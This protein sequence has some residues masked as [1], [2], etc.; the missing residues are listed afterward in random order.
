M[1]VSNLHPT[2]LPLGEGVNIMDV[3]WAQREFEGANLRDKRFHRSLPEIAN[4]LFCASECS[5]TQAVGQDGRQ[6]AHRLMSNPL[7]NINSI[8][9]GHYKQ[10]A[11]RASAYPLILALQDTVCIGYDTH[12]AKQ[13]LGPIDNR[14]DGRGLLGHEVFVATPDGLPLGVMDLVIWARDPHEHGKGKDRRAKPTHLK[15]SQKWINGERALLARLPD[16]QYVILIQD[17]EADIYDFL[18]TERRQGVDFIVRA[19]HPRAV[20]VSDTADEPFCRKTDLLTASREAPIVGTMEVSVPRTQDHPERQAHLTLRAT[21]LR[22]LAPRDRHL[23]TDKPWVDLRVVSATE[24]DAPQGRTPIHWV[25]LT[26]LPVDTAEDASLAVTRYSRRWLIERLHHTLKSGQ[27]AEKLQISDLHALCNTLA[28]LFIVAWRVM[29]VAHLNRT[30]P[31]L[32]A[33]EVVSP[34]ELDVLEAETNAQITTVGQA[35]LAIAKLGG[36]QAYRS[37][38]PPGTVSIW[39]GIRRLEALTHGWHL[40]RKALFLSYR[41]DV[42]PV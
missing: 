30:N 4:R 29:H 35:V 2:L 26:S 23:D 27:R 12:H 16:G 37:A 40:C 19:T 1:P 33:L 18:A 6:A 8:M 11:Q 20:L 7:I 17:R 39:R 25:L 3:L 36:Y 10:T 38:P 32:P 41:R 24:E 34:T 42:N 21:R 31:D 15:E 28:L 5:F 14:P 9:S 13:G 22:V